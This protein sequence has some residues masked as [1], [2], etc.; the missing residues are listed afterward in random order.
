MP[1]SPLSLL[2]KRHGISCAKGKR[3]EGILMDAEVRRALGHF[4]RCPDDILAEMVTLEE[5]DI[6]ID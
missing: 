3:S 5:A 6:I 4:I 1:I 2:H